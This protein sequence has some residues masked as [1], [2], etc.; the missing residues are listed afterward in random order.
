MGLGGGP[1]QC[2]SHR[3]LRGCSPQ[4]YL[5]CNQPLAGRALVK[6]AYNNDCWPLISSGMRRAGADR[7]RSVMGNQTLYF[8][9]YPLILAAVD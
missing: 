5:K 7:L 3:T 8:F 9:E 2:S 4:Q 1:Y 6:H